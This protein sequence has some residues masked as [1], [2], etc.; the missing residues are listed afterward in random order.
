M[1]YQYSGAVDD[2]SMVGLGHRLGAQYL[3]YGSFEQYG[4]M[5]QLTIQATGVE[6]GEILYLKSYIIT[7]TSQITDLFD[8]DMELLTAEDYLDAIARCQK[9][10]N[11]NRKREIKGCSKSKSKDSA[12]VSGAN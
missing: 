12:E 4:G 11:F 9:K 3:I 7:K 10:N 2:D 5:L 1:M 6:G 8:D